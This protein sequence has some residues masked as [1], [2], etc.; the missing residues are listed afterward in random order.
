M[1]IGT[2]KEIKNNENRVGLTPNGAKELTEAGHKVLIEKHAGK[3]SGFSDKEYIKAGAEISSR[4][5]VWEAEMIIKVK[6]PVCDEYDLLKENQILFT[7][8]HLAGVDT[9]LTKLLL[10]KK[11]TA[12]AYETVEDEKGGLP[13]LK[14]MSEVAGKMAVQVGSEYL[15]KYKRGSGVLIDG[16]SNVEPGIVAIIGLGNVGFNSA[17]VAVGRGAKVVLVDRNKDKLDH[18]LEY[19]KDFR[20]ENVTALL[21]TPENQEKIDDAVRSSDVLIGAVLVAGAKALHVVSE[22]LVKQMKKGSV[23]VDVAIDQG[24]CI[25]TSRPTSHSKPVYRK[26]GVIHYCVTNM[27]GAYPRTSTFGLTNATLPYAKKIAEDLIKNAKA[28]TGLAKGINCYKGDVTNKGVAEALGYEYKE[29][30]L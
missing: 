23:I 4:E 28:D 3:G 1:I 15:A 27:P 18:C 7:Y 19:F 5:K 2:P 30:I 25:E 12:I 26:H 13:L 22:K 20:N 9:M 29:L 14:P 11:V 24:G 10:Q 21:S 6:E 16:I 17:M 8:L